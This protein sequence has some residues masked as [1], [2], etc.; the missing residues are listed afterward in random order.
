MNPI[1]SLTP[2]RLLISNLVS[3]THSALLRAHL[4]CPSCTSSDAYAE[5]DDGHGFCYSCNLYES[6]YKRDNVDY[7]YQ[8]LPWRSVTRESFE[9]YGVKTKCE[10]DGKPI[11]LSYPYPNGATKVRLLDTKDFYSTGE[12]SKAGLFGQQL[13]D[14]LAH[15]SVTICEGELDAISA[16]QILGTPCVSVSSASNG[17]RDCTRSFDWLRGFETIYLAL[18]NDA[19]G[20]SA[21]ASIARL[22]DYGRV[23]DVRLLK[24]KDAN[25][26]LQNGEIAEFRSIWY[27]AKNFMPEGIKSSVADFKSILE[28]QPTSGMPY[29]PFGPLTDMTYGIRTGET[30]LVTAQ[31][32]VG[33]TEFLHGLEYDLCTRGTRVGGFFLEETPQRHLQSLAGIHLRR[34]VHLPDSGVTMGEVS[35]AIG[36]ILPQDDLLF[37][38]TEFG[39][40]DI[41]HLLG[42]IRFLVVGCDVR[43]VILDHVS[44]A[45]SGLEGDQQRIA[46]DKFFTQ[47][48]TMVKELDF[49]LIVVSH[50][51]DYGQ[52]RGSRW[53]G[54]MADIRID[55]VRDV[56]NGS[57]VLDVYVSK[58]RFCGRTGHAGSYEFNA[59]TRQYTLVGDN[60][61]EKI[62]AAA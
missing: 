24:H 60:D 13:F 38:D 10:Q 35:N 47:A 41:E 40:H 12:I 21:S 26:Y 55:L 43:V 3:A 15:K 14:P 5:Y 6:K 29:G 59:Y 34:P 50:V 9:F 25:E 48:E 18:D 32:G 37:M 20:R 42:T 11:S 52:T 23:K 36:E 16:Y 8:Y 51:N 49:S 57:N 30:V 1:I 2:R 58:N 61:N 27:S 4:P 22:F 56:A 44:V 45:V 53:G 46:L 28:A 17:L 39:S 33:K 19:P 31:E 62:L 54:K 7:S